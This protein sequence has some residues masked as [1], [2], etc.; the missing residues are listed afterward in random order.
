VGDVTGLPRSVCKVFEFPDAFVAVSGKITV[1]ETGFDFGRLI[2]EALT[3]EG[4]IEKQA[5]APCQKGR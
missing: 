1:K 5:S 4:E 2:E 3:T